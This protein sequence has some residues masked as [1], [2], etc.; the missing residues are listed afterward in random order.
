MTKELL[1]IKI[2]SLPADKVDAV[3]AFIDFI[4][5]AKNDAIITEQ[6]L[7]LQMESGAFNFLNDEPELYSDK[8]FIE[9]YQWKNLKPAS[10]IKIIIFKLINP[11][12]LYSTFNGHLLHH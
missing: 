12:T 3:G 9:K 8:N 4:L 10:M 7:R 11:S 5:Y 2:D 1:K 6:L